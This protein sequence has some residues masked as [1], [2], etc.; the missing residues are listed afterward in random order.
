M[1]AAEIRDSGAVLGTALDETAELARDVHRAV[2]GRLFGLLGKVGAPIRVLH[3][4]IATVAYGGTRLGVKYLPTAA[5]AS[6]PRSTTQRGVGERQSARALRPQRARRL[7]RRPLRRRE[8]LAGA[9]DEP[10]HA[11]RTA[12]QRPGQRRPRPAATPPPDASSC[13]PTDCARTSGSG[14]TAPSATTA[15]ATSRTARSCATSRAGRRSTCTT[16]PACTSPRTAACS[17][18]TSRSLVAAWPVAV[19]EIALVG[20]SMGGLIV[21]SA[22]HQAA[23]HDLTGCSRCGTSSGSARRTPAPR[24]SGRPTPACTCSPNCPRRVRSRRTST[25][26]ASVS[27]TCATAR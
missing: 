22:A 5:G 23:E 24:S 7:G 12:A 25:S 1:Q 13:S 26:A 4:S 27:R 3:D 11:R 14:G 8:R 15:T 21:R 16:T 9:G 20:H 18:A 2:A 6:R 10:A 17:R 19:T